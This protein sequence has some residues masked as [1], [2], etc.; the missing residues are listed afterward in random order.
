[1]DQVGKLSMLRRLNAS[2][3]SSD[4]ALGEEAADLAVRPQMMPSDAAA[5]MDRAVAEE[6]IVLRSY[7]PVLAIKNNEIELAFKDKSDGAVWEERLKEAKPVLD[8][9]IRAVGR[10]EL[11]R[12]GFEW[13]GTGWLVAENVIVTNRHVANE[14]AEKQSDSFTFKMGVGG[15]VGAA[16]DFLQE[17]DSSQQ[18]IFGLVRPLHI[19]PAT[20]PDVALFEIE[21]LSG[22]SQLAQPIPLSAKP[23][24]SNA[25]VVIGY[26]A[27]DSRIPEADLMNSIFG[28]V[29]NKKRLAPGAITLVD[30]VKL[31]HNCTTLGG[32]SGSVLL[33]LESGEA[34]G[35]HFSGTFLTANYAVRSDIVAKVVA[36]ANSGRSRREF[37][38]RVS[39]PPPRAAVGTPRNVSFTI[40]VT[41]TV[42]IGEVDAV[43]TRRSDLSR[44]S[45]DKPEEGVEARTAHH[46][47]AD[48]RDGPRAV[49][50]HFLSIFQSAAADFA[51]QIDAEESSASAAH[52]SRIREAADELAD[53]RFG[54]RSET[55]E[56]EEEGIADVSKICASLGLRYLEAAVGG[57]ASR[58]ESIRQQMTAGTCD[59]RWASTLTEYVKYFGVN[60]TRAQIPYVRP[61]AVGDRTIPISAGARIAVFGDW[62]TGAARAR[63]VLAA[64]KQ[65]KP[66]ILLHLGDIYYSGTPA[67]C[68]TNFKAT[69]REAFGGGIPVFTLAGNH[70]MYCGG[71]GYYELVRTQ[72]RDSLAQ[73]SSFFCLRCT[74]SSWQI[75]AA[76]TG[77]HDYSPLVVTDALTY[78]EDEE[79]AWLEQ[80]VRE[81]PGRTI[82]VSHHQLFSAFSQIGKP[83]TDGKLLP[84]NPNL[85]ALLRRLEAAGD[86]AAWFWG[87]EHNMCIYEPFLGLERG[88]CLGHGAIPVLEEQKPYEVLKNSLSGQPSLVSETRLQVKDGA[89]ENGFAVVTLGER[90]TAATV[91]YFTTDRGAIYREQF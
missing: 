3:R 67:E 78:V 25:V 85:L 83:G 60:G 20:G 79:Q 69:I 81:F 45:A 27:Y 72:N 87:H 68:S 86:V 49:R 77:L 14:F 39:T 52:A 2:I 23:A 15:K 1:M 76:D 71:S 57:D 35:L 33:D 50:D 53:I 31:Q 65:Q 18:L 91:E 44:T 54:H 61:L 90:G 32:N 63:T 16:V 58:A 55:A 62:G 9:A 17:I 5:D 29:Y 82:L 48:R 84:Y 75:L 26:P 13:I 41:V 64:I 73:N 40:P 37:P 8:M 24:V 80:R 70:D 47:G 10:I 56:W 46:N 51:S 36:E 19:E 38:N 28:N 4:R 6:S 88:R 74:D 59:P 43:S 66:D 42:S 7:R 34:F 21:M 89:Y 11:M 12:A 22:D 30:S